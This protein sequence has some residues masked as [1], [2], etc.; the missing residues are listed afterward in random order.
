M[1]FQKWLE[2]TTTTA[3][4]AQNLAKGQVDVIGAKR[5]CPEG[6][7]WDAKQLECV[8][9]IKIKEAKKMKIGFDQEGY[10]KLV[11]HFMD[12][13][14][15]SKREAKKKADKYKTEFRTYEEKKECPD[16]HEWDEKMQECLPSSTGIKEEKFPCPD[17]HEWDEKL[18]EC[19]PKISKLKEALMM[20]VSMKDVPKEYLK[21][22]LYKKVLVAKNKAE[23]DKALDALKQI[24]G[25]SAV[26]NFVKK[27]KS[28][29]EA[30]KPSTPE[31]HQLKIA[32]DTLKMTDAMAKIMGGMT[33]EE[34]KRIIEKFSKKGK[35]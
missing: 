4:V 10:D 33:K 25:E 27:V 16:G 19:V 14:G 6:M 35:K 20:E 2:E 34:A 17:T 11:K 31:E 32:K 3:G 12:K 29:K 22:P 26:R 30:K 7:T 18:Q 8:P 23:Y 28:L 13:Q 1:R 5:K 24:R 21:D 15:L 9:D